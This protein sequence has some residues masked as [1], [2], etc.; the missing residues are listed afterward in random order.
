MSNTYFENVAIELNKAFIYF[1]DIDSYLD[2]VEKR[3]NPDF[4]KQIRQEKNVNNALKIINDNNRF[5]LIAER[6]FFKR[7]LLDGFYKDKLRS[8]LPIIDKLITRLETEFE[9]EVSNFMKISLP[10]DLVFLMESYNNGLPWQ[11]DEVLIP[12]EESEGYSNGFKIESNNKSSN[13]IDWRG[14]QRLIP[15][16]F[17]LLNKVGFIDEKDIFKLASETFTSKGKPI[18]R[19]HLA[20][21]YSQ[22]DYD[23]K[24]SK[25][26]PKEAQ[27][28]KLIV[29]KLQEIDEILESLT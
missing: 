7:I 20:S 26:L 11:I 28:I 27:K 2:E 29:D 18:N 23:G 8:L 12:N 13:K 4:L 24:K 15:Y 6:L 22:G 17:R 3:I 9:E 19:E 5:K 21:N 25:E 16:L 1:E 10:K 14:N